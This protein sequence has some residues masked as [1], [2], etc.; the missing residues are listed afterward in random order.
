MNIRAKND[1]NDIKTG[2][3]QCR[4]INRYQSFGIV[5][6]RAIVFYIPPAIS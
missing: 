4:R 6:C 1:K 5:M 3:K 2:I